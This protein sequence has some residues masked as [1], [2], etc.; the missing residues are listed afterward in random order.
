MDVNDSSLTVTPDGTKN[1]DPFFLGQKKNAVEYLGDP[2]K[3]NGDPD[4]DNSFLGDIHGV[5]LITG[6]CDE[7]V[8]EK[9]EDVLQIFHSSSIKEIKSILGDGR[10][11]PFSAHEQSVFNCCLRCRITILNLDSV[12]VS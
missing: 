6:D 5:I 7:T 1:P 3:S 12:L 4:W 9:K 10:E 8:G 11:D 2:K